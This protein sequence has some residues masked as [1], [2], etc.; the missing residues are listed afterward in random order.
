MGFPKNKSVPNFNLLL[1]YK[2]STATIH[3]KSSCRC[4]LRLF[5]VGE[6]GEGVEDDGEDAELYS[7][8]PPHRYSTEKNENFYV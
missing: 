6:G 4:S 3:F 8:K 5:L 1:L 7:Y 2:K